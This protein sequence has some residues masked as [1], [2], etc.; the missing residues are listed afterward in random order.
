MMYLKCLILFL[1]VPLIAAE[2]TFIYLVRHAEKVD[3]SKDPE[4]SP[5][6]QQRAQAL[7]DFFMKVPVSEL[8]AS[9]Y[10]R[11]QKTLAPLAAQ[12][13]LSVH[14]IPASKPEALVAK[15]RA[16]TGVVVISGHSNT[17]PG[18]I[19]RLGAGSVIIE[20]SDYRNLFLLVLI[21][22]EATLQTFQ[23]EP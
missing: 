14:I 3:A 15:V 19:E 17:L 1:Y 22:K 7:A 2:P 4:L 23:L 13:Q 8:Y 10:Q 5:R 18:L 21:E 9:E 11:T 20:D 16:A 12:K 6:G